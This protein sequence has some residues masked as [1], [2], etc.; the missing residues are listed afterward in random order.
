[1]ISGNARYFK[2]L[3]RQICEQNIKSYQYLYGNKD[4]ILDYNGFWSKNYCDINVFYKN[5]IK[6]TKT[7]LFFLVKAGHALL[8]LCELVIILLTMESKPANYMKIYYS[9]LG[10]TPLHLFMYQNICLHGESFL[11]HNSL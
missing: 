5:I 7:Q 1:M 2:C 6:G 9:A 10:E 8:Y 3:L 11:C 4:K